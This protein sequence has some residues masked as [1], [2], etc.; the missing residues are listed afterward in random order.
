MLVQGRRYP[1]VGRIT[2][3]ALMV[4][5][6]QDSA[7]N[8]DPVTLLGQ[9]GE[10]RITVEEVASW[11]GSIPYEVLTMINTRVPRVYRD[12]ASSPSA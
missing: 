3:D 1:V 7:H 2:M 10:A 9:Q 5:I 4:N 6:G 8:A 12:D 11:L